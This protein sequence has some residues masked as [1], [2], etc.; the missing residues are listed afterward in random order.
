MKLK[1][2]LPILFIA[3]VIF[4]LYVPVS[5]VITH[6]RVYSSGKTYKMEL[7]P[8]DPNDP[9][10]GKYI[11]LSFKETT[12]N[13]PKTGNYSQGQDVY[14]C[15]KPDQNDFLQIDSI[16][17]GYQ[18][19]KSPAVCMKASIRSITEYDGYKQAQ[20]VYPFT[21]FYV[22]E[23][24]AAT[25]EQRYLKALGDTVNPSYGLLKVYNEN[26]VVTDVII[27]GESLIRSK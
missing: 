9:F 2:Y 10:R 15:M 7:A 13:L 19:L 11:I 24:K 25:I 1:F 8:I 6:E 23:S 3:L 18:L 4:Q 20:L 16:S 12:A 14:V 26:V 17:A 27:N 5:M 21:R 22:E